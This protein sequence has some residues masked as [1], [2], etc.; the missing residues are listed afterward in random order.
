[1]AV[2]EGMLPKY[3][4]FILIFNITVPFSHAYFIEEIGPSDC[5]TGDD[6]EYHE[7]FDISQLRCLRCSQMS[8][9]QT[10]SNDGT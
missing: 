10:V 1:M 3:L 7:Y 5:K 4:I 2:V 9:L 6:D 8:T